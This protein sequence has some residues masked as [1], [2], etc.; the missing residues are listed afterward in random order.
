M[1]WEKIL[2]LLKFY[3]AITE[4]SVQTGTK[5]EMMTN[6]TTH[7]ADAHFVRNKP[8]KKYAAGR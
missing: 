6:T 8:K 7:T 4:K 5:M 1:A 3:G 2:I